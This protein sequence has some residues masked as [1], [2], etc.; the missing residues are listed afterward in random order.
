MNFIQIKEVFL[1]Y[2]KYF[3]SVLFLNHFTKKFIENP[4]LSLEDKIN[5][6]FVIENFDDLLSEYGLNLN[7]N[8]EIRKKL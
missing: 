5:P 2:L 3:K 8:L 6:N 4:Q 7:L 1:N